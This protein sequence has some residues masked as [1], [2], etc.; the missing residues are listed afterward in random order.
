MKLK[1]RRVLLPFITL[2]FAAVCLGADTIKPDDSVLNPIGAG[3]LP[4][5][6]SK[7]LD[8]WHAEPE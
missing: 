5:F 4:L 3:W 2:A 6:N 7:N 1:S 8:G